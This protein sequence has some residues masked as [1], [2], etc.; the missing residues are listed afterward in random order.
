MSN[1]QVIEGWD[2]Y[3]LAIVDTNVTD[4]WA[5]T[6][7]VF[8]AT[9]E[10]R[11][12]TRSLRFTDPTAQVNRA[13]TAPTSVIYIGY[14]V[15]EN[16]YNEGQ[17]QAS[18]GF[19]LEGNTNLELRRTTDNGIY[20]L[21]NG[22]SVLATTN[23]LPEDTYHY[24]LVKYNTNSGAWELFANREPVSSG[25]STAITS[26]NLVRWRPNGGQQ[27]GSTET[28]VDDIFVWTDPNAAEASVIEARRDF[29]VLIT[30][31]AS[32][33]SNTGWNVNGVSTADQALDN[34]PPV[35]AQNVEAVSV[36]SN[37]VLEY[38]DISSS[39]VNVLGVQLTLRG[40]KTDAADGTLRTSLIVSG[41]SAD[42]DDIFLAVNSAYYSEI[43][44]SAPNGDTWSVDDLSKL[45]ASITR[46]E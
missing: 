33:V 4:G 6:G 8:V 14:G 16:T 1:L 10:P 3:E 17:L 20:T 18:R 15:R 43:F 26:V 23:A 13:I 39:V 27:G 12:G 34:I 5:S 32:T 7:F 21:F 41:V 2:F 22:T 37:V 30:T 46:V 38:G 42:S 29:K 11:T 36:S 45:R 44:T 24:F 25:G 31:A 35:S 19:S 9:T 28:Y 40:R